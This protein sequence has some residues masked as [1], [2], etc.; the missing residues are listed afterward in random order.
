MSEIARLESLDDFCRPLGVQVMNPL[1]TVVDLSK[2][3]ALPHL[4]QNYGFYAVFSKELAC[5]ELSYGRGRYDYQEGTFVFIAPGQVAGVDDGGITLHPKGQ[6]L[7][8]LSDLIHGTSLAKRMK[9][10][11]FFLYDSN[12]SLHVSCQER[13]KILKGFDRLSAELSRGAAQF[14]RRKASDIICS[15]LDCCKKCYDRQFL[16]RKQMNADLLARF[17]RLLIEYFRSD[18]PLRIGFPTVNYCAMELCL[19]TNYFGDLVRRETG[20][21]PREYIQ[22]AL[23]EQI[24]RRLADTQG[25][26]NRI[27]LE[28][29]FK[30]PQHMSRMFKKITGLSPTEFRDRTQG[31]LPKDKPEI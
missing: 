10:Y 15:I 7:L 18:L 25:S 30:Y 17:E 21:T 20:M 19:S 14:D 6:A 12:E 8:F 27:A 9:E 3:E 28:L 23:V 4:R 31:G 22:M 16:T 2:V 24:K 1:V 26:V 13:Q 29:G 5:G 11:T